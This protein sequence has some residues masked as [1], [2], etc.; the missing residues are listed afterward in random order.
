VAGAG[1]T[2]LALALASQDALKNIFG[3]IEL[4]LDKPFDVGQ[5]VKLKGYDGTIEEIGLR[6][7]KI[8]TLTGHQITMP[9]DDVAKLDVENIDRSPYI[10]RSSNI[11][12]PY[13][14]P[15]DKI[16]RAVEIVREVLSVSE[17][18]SRALVNNQCINHPGFPPRVYF[19][20]FNP[21]SLN[22]LLSYWY[23]PSDYWGFLNHSHEINVQ[24]VERF[25]AENIEFAFPS[26]TLYH[27]S[28]A[29]RPLIIDNNN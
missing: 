12:I 15:P 2:G 11:T 28:D 13:D 10:R 20:E 24:I 29:R 7:T 19:N 26:Q 25:N 27:A 1:F 6:S 17:D 5:R 16:N 3:G 22:I 9:N 18:S 14:T 4:A 23:H 21:D 8:R